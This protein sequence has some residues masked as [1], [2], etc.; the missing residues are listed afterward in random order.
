LRERTAALLQERVSVAVG[1][2]GVEA[3]E[4]QQGFQGRFASR[5]QTAA[6]SARAAAPI[7][8]DSATVLSKARRNSAAGICSLPRR[9]ARMKF[10]APS[11]HD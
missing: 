6:R 9:S 4:E 5:S 10:I 2:D 1:L 3:F 11:K 7:S 8:A